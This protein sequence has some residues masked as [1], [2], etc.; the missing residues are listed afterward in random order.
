MEAVEAV[1]AVEADDNP[2]SAGRDGDLLF[3]DSAFL[4]PDVSE[5]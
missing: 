1:E 2:L 5:Q 3:S 4:G